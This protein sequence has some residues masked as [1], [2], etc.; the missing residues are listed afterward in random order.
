MFTYILPWNLKYKVLFQYH[1]I[2]YLCFINELL[3]HLGE[4]DSC[5]EGFCMLTVLEPDSQ[6]VSIFA[7]ALQIHWR[8]WMHISSHV[9]CAACLWGSASQ[10]SQGCHSLTQLLRRWPHQKIISLLLHNYNSAVMNP[11]INSIN[12]C[13]PIILSDPCERVNWPP[14]GGGG[15]AGRVTHRLR[16]TAII[17][18][19][20]KFAGLNKK[21]ILCPVCL[22][23]NV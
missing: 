11:V 21:T 22:K 2:I 16:T 17:A 18:T 14:N 9:D 23:I 7:L 13:F 3:K 10:P 19:Y 12:K 8:W 20:L 6:T 4:N 1:R 15:A 5:T